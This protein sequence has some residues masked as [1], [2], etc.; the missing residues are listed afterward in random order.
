MNY[1]KIYD[2]LNIKIEKIEYYIPTIDWN[3]V[4]TKGVDDFVNKRINKKVLISNGII[5]SGQCPTFD[6]NSII[7]RLSNEYKNIDFIITDDKIKNDNIFY[8]GDI[9]KQSESDLNE[10]SYLSKFC[11][12][13]VGRASGPF[14]FC[15]I[16]DNFED[17][18]K[19]FIGFTN[20][21]YDS[22]WYEE[23]NCVQIWSDNYN[24]V[25]ETIKNEIEK[26]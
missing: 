23:V 13:I 17:K 15:H 18:N 24:N 21:K 14:A 20:N 9:I 2:L 3:K 4:N 19:K 7:K 6:I 5:L 1:I 22:I 25:Y 16:K 10:I 26:L 12:I 11:D 8:C